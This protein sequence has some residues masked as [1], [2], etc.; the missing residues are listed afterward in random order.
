VVAAVAGGA[1]TVEE[2]DIASRTIDRLRAAIETDE[3]A[4]VVDRMESE[5]GEA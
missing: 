3:I 2:G 1:L 5:G 4:Q